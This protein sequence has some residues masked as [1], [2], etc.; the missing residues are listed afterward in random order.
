VEQINGDATLSDRAST[1]KIRMLTLMVL[2]CERLMGDR[3]SEEQTRA[4]AARLYNQWV[5]FLHHDRWFSDTPR[6]EC[7]SAEGEALTARMKS[8]IDGLMDRLPE[9]GALQLGPRRKNGKALE[10]QLVGRAVSIIEEK[11]RQVLL[12]MTAHIGGK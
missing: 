1:S 8:F 2:F 3:S 4:Q 7:L 9:T 5:C 10:G 6:P 11:G 12:A